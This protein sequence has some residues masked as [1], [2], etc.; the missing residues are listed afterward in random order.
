LQNSCIKHKEKKKRGESE[1][2]KEKKN[3]VPGWKI[4]IGKLQIQ[5]LRI[6]SIVVIVAWY[7]A[8]L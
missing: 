8:M 7:V 6:L 1:K 4:I 3:F 5:P 2:E